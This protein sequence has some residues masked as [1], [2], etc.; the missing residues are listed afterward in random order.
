[1]IA[2]LF[3]RNIN[4]TEIL[5]FSKEPNL[6]IQQVVESPLIRFLGSI[7]PGI[8]PD[9]KYIILGKEFKC[10]YSLKRHSDGVVTEMMEFTTKEFDHNLRPIYLGYENNLLTNLR[11]VNPTKIYTNHGL[12]SEIL[13]IVWIKTATEIRRNIIAK[14]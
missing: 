10:K 11:L 4:F 6:E 2:Q 12:H 1:M 5:D 13:P 9:E 14:I 3:Q 8:S 7:L